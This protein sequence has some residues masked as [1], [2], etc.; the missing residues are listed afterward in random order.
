V[1]RLRIVSV[2]LG[3]MDPGILV[4]DKRTWLLAVYR[5]LLA[6]K[7]GLKMFKASSTHKMDITE[8][9]KFSK[10]KV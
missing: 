6:K 7:F 8:I 10:Q 4:L 3:N 5:F 2:G 1:R 9:L